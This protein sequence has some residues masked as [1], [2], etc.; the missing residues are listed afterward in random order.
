MN[1]ILLEIGTEEIPSIYIDKT[2]KNLKNITIKELKHLNID[3]NNIYTYGTPR[4]IILYIENIQSQ[5]SDIFQKIKGPSKKISFDEDG[6]PQKPAIKFAQSNQVKID[7][8]INEQTDKGEYLFAKKVIKGKR[9]EELLPEIC[10]KLISSLSFPKS[11]RWGKNSFRFIRPIRWFLALYNEKIIPFYLETLKSDRITYGHRLLSPEPV[12]ID[13]VDHYFKVLEECFVSIDPE[14]RKKMVHEQIIEITEE[15][16]WENTIDEELL[17][18]VKNLVEYPRVLLGQFSTDYLKLPTEVLKAVMIKHQKYFPIYKKKDMLSP[19][20][21]VVINGNK[22]KFKKPIILGNE[23]VLKARLEDARFFYQEDQR[24]VDKNLKPLDQKLDKLRNVVYQE[25]LGSM[26][27]KV[28]RLIGLTG[29]MSEDLELENNLS[30]IIKRS[31]Q[32]CKADLVSEMVKE[33]P[34]L[35]GIMG[36]EYALLQQE[37]KR[38]ALAIFEHYLPRFSGDSLPKTISGS[39]LSVADKLDN[40]T[41][42]FINGNI[43]DGSQDPYALRRQSLGIINIVLLN[44]LDF[45]LSDIIEYNI[46]LLVR[47][48]KQLEKKK[49]YSET[50]KSEIFDFVLQRFR[51]LLLEKGYRYDVIDAV[52]VK[53]PKNIIDALLRIKVIQ[54]IYNLPKFNKIITAAT[55]TFNLSKNAIGLSVDPSYFREKEEK[56]LY[57][58]Y[59]ETKK[60]IENA[61]LRQQYGMV[62]DYLEIMT[63]PVDI[64][65]DHVLVM[66][67][68]ELI[69]KNRLAL[70]KAIANLYHKIADLSR[71]ALAKGGLK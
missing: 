5:Q 60:K 8:L 24:V 44:E 57:E 33:F 1:K 37:D 28:N 4:R 2:L 7:E 10:L 9:T 17:D 51:H 49:I 20:F 6:N 53:K 18:E 27:N 31:A 46:K 19:H 62:F 3:C 39:I 66:E 26:Y 54:E 42:C 29:K 48:N 41:S 16:H 45:N 69:R 68:D 23:R 63:E 65:F 47:N 11:M 32:L 70:L 14:V 67:K 64:F 40:I 50:L 36:K 21:F 71:I 35:Q 55:R 56:N 13:K 38:V 52:L 61:I 34:E 25:N 43:P 59:L 15:N 12:K 58:Q 30:Q 22:D